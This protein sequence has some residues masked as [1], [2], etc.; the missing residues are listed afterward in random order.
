MKRVLL[1]ATLMLTLVASTACAQGGLYLRVGDCAAGSSVQSINNDCSRNDSLAIDLVA[2]C[3]VPID[4]PDFIGAATMIDV[5]ASSPALP[6][7]WRLDA[8]GCRKGAAS[9]V[10]SQTIAPSCQ[11]LWDG[12]I[13]FLPLLAVQPFVGGP[14]R[15]RLNMGC[16]LRA[17]TLIVG[18]GVTEQAV[19]RLQIAR[20][21]SAGTGSCAGCMTDMTIVLSEINLQPATI[22]VPWLRITNPAEPNS[23]FVDY[24]GSDY[25]PTRNRTWGAVKALYR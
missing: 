20:A 8:A 14:N 9:V 2:S 7:W 12:F 15:V 21:K 23:N 13:E 24:T 11:T 25:T 3:I 4:F 6:D 1:V 22:A 17:P 5:W 16:A 10:Y 18:D 19:V